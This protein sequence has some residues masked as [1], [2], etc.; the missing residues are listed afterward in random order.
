[1]PKGIQIQSNRWVQIVFVAL[2]VVASFLIGSLYTKVQYLEKSSAS[3]SAAAG[4]TV[5]NNGKYASYEDAVKA[6]AK[7]V[8]LDANKLVACMNS[9][10]KKAIVD[11]DVAQGTSVGVEGTPG[12]FVNGKFLGGAFPTAIFKEIIDKELAGKSSTVATDYSDYLQKAVQQNAFNPTPKTI[13]IGN[14]PI[15]GA[16]NAKVTIVVFSDFQCPYC[17]QGYTTM[18]EILKAYPDSVRLVFKNFPLS[19]HPRSHI[20]AEAA[21]CA[22]DQ[23]KFWEFH[24]AMFEAQSDWTSL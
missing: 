23:G 2:L 6:I 5:V 19:F 16:A 21:E 12:F 11:A 14:A 22:K 18:Q 10:E 17:K 1:M 4:G 3:P 9:G 7:S 24:N 20:S 15:E 13:D 8:K